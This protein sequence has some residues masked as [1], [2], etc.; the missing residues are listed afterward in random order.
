M[1]IETVQAPAVGHRRRWPVLAVVLIAEAMDILDTTTV[2][3][4]GPAVRRSLG[5]GIGL[6]Q[7]LSAAYTLAFAVLLITGG[8]LGDRYGP[9]RMFL[10]GAAGFTAASVLCGLSVSPA[11]LIGFRLVQGAF[12][13]VLLPQGIRLL[14]AAFSGRDLGRA[15]SAYA[16]VLSLAAVTGPLAAGA[17]IHWN[18][19]GT[20][21]RLIFLINLVL[22]A[23][24]LAGGFRYLP[25]D[26]P[27]TLRRLDGRG[28]LIVAAAMFGVV[29]PLIQ[30]RELGW[31]W[32]TF[33]V[34]AAGLAGFG[35]FA[36]HERRSPAPLIEPALLRRRTFLTGAAV[37]LAFFAATAGIMLVLSFYAQY[38]LGYSALGAGLTLTPVAAGNV[39][40]ALVALRLADRFG[41]RATIAV[42][43]AVALAGLISLAGLALATTRP[44]GL[45]LAGPA[46]A[47]GFGLGGII[48]P[49]FATILVGVT[50]AE[51]GSAAGSLGA[52]Q[53]LAGSV[54]VAT[55]AT[56]YTA[57]SHPAA[58]GLAITALATATLLA[59]AAA[60]TLLLPAGEAGQRSNPK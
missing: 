53:Q 31:P 35:G 44:D 39:T 27:A 46:L 38:G 34:L 59:V 51:T 52:I 50:P 19:W 37:A 12:G 10:V 58:R 16:P 5:G 29:Y 45:E 40:G 42:N 26:G 20:G 11:M 17:L 15:F 14:T 36:R 9:R 41:G 56:L 3:V 60:L 54:G 7:W 6:V 23:A 13:A 4:A 48:A 28:V 21:W 18:L 30:G 55:L 8:R 2:N 32:W 24:A 25:A 22:G 43:L 47:L 33:A 57:T 1:A 49:L